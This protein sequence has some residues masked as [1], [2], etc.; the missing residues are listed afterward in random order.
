MARNDGWAANWTCE[1]LLGHDKIKSAEVIGPNLISCTVNKVDEPILVAT[2]SVDEV[3]EKVL[4]ET[5]VDADIQFVMNIKSDAL[6]SLNAIDYAQTMNI[7]LGGLGDLYTAVNERDFRDYIPKGSRFILRGLSQH[8]N[9]STVRRLTNKM[10]EI[11]TGTGNVLRVLALDEYDLTADA[12]RTG[13]EKHG[14]CDL[15]LAS[16]PNCGLTDQSKSAAK[17]CGARAVK[18][19]QLLG[20]LKN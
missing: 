19:N 9:V 18:W 4:Q 2:I 1:K 6:I 16:N 10:Y 3:T 13:I 11:A 8:T 17:A 20:V 5:L 12:V 14:K 15:V 7:G